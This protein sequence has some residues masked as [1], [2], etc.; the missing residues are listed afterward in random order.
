[1]ATQA[2][3]E[4]GL[5]GWVF[6]HPINGRTLPCILRLLSRNHGNYSLHPIGNKSEPI[7]F[8]CRGVKVEKN[9]FIHIHAIV[10][11]EDGNESQR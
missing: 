11:G 6:Y 3:L 4:G 7:L 1:M 2:E 10:P 9:S 8:N 5:E